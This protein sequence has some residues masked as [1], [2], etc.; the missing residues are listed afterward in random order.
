L[1]GAGQLCG[2]AEP[3]GQ[4]PGFRGCRAAVMLSSRQTRAPPRAILLWRPGGNAKFRVC[5]RWARSHPGTG[6]PGTPVRVL[7]LH[8]P[9][10]QPSSTTRP[11]KPLRARV[12][13]PPVQGSTRSSLLLPTRS[14]ARR[15]VMAAAGARLMPCAGG[16]DASPSRQGVEFVLASPA[17]GRSTGPA[18]GLPTRSGGELSVS[19]ATRLDDRCGVSRQDVRLVSS[20]L[21]AIAEERGTKS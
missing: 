8:A 2:A 10:R 7:A 18:A 6:P 5:H 9:G 15:T 1:C 3:P 21:S 19:S 20:F 12:R 14:H 4:R 16:G 17:S 11:P 13:A